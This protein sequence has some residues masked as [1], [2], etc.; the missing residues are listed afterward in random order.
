MKNR[1]DYFR[2]RRKN[3]IQK[4]LCSRCLVPTHAG[5]DCAQ[6]REIKAEKMR[7]S[8]VAHNIDKTKNSAQ[9]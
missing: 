3:L 2:D 1:A 7:N 9:P 5:R 8:R 6:C 4:K